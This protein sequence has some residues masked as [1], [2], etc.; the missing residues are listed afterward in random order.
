MTV[1]WLHYSLR[2][3]DHRDEV[4]DQDSFSA[5][6]DAAA[7]ETAR[8]LYDVNIGKGYA[9]WKHDRHVHTEIYGPKSRR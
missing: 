1:Y 6:H 2:F 9:I 5:S 8:R 4:F 7:I 3:Y